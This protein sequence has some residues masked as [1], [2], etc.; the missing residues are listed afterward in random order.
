MVKIF[1]GVFYFFDKMQIMQGLLF[2]HRMRSLFLTQTVE[3]FCLHG[4]EIIIQKVC[5]LS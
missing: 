1:R 3:E 2:G 4:T 5:Q